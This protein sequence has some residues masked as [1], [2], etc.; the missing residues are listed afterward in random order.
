V[1]KITFFL[2]VIC[3][4][5]S[6]LYA[7]TN[8]W[9]VAASFGVASPVGKFGNTD[10]FDSTSAFAKTGFAINVEAVYRFSKYFGVSILLT[11]QNNPV[12]TKVMRQKFEKTVPGAYFDITSGDWNIGK[13]MA[14]VY[15]T[16]PLDDEER[17]NL[18][19][20]LMAGGMKT[21]LP[22]IKVTEVFYSDSLGNIAASQFSQN[23]VPLS[24]T[25]AYLIGVGAKLNLSK[26]YFVQGSIDF[27]GASPKVPN[28]PLGARVINP[29]IYGI[30]GNPFPT[31]IPNSDNA[32]DY[33]QPIQSLTFALGVG[34]NF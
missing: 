10:I 12:D 30:S 7:Q 26:T 27:A 34:I 9:S 19:L 6:N 11:G 14:G 2:F 20:R 32:K 1:K 3:I 13:A 33:K 8:R 31:Y 18:F 25:F 4:T 21:T 22:K 28:Y 16:V 5:A 23:K 29:G 24:W 17:L 15:L